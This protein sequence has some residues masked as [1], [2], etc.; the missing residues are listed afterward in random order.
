[1]LLDGRTRGSLAGDRE[2]LDGLRAAVKD[3]TD[4]EGE[5]RVVDRENI[6]IVYAGD[7]PGERRALLVVPLRLGL[8]QVNDTMWYEAPLGA[9]PEQMEWAGSASVGD[10]VT[11]YEADSE[12]PGGLLVLTPPGASVEY[13]TRVTYGADGRVHH[14]WTRAQADDG[15][16]VADLPPSDRPPL[17][18]A[19]VRD[20]GEEIYRDQVIGDWQPPAG[21]SPR[22]PRSVLVEATRQTRGD[23]VDP[24]F[25]RSMLDDVLSD[26]GLSI[27][28]RLTIRVPWSGR[29]AD[30]DALLLTVQPED[31]GV[32]AYGWS[33]RFDGIR[34]DLR[35]LLPAQGVTTR[36]IAWR[37]ES[38]ESKA[39]TSTVMVVAPEGA[40]S[41][42]LVTE[43]GV[44]PVELDASGAGQ[45]SV[46]AEQRA[47]VRAYG[48]DGELLGETP[49][50]LLKGEWHLGVPGD[51]PETRVVP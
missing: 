31:G 9:Q 27:E 11:H 5:W 1:M 19:R 6:D 51:K 48:A 30:R 25:L 16:V 23:A 14:N 33:R 10:V 3:R 28:D 45:A 38:E 36:P 8:I 24:G 22:I 39:S 13:S 26:A 50:P 12:G 18:H 37:V 21:W 41:A 32:L 29:V 44:E 35:L 47:T 20:G 43:R 46:E 40:V 2:W 4:P 15:V 17:V 49:V 34:Q 42:E 7:L